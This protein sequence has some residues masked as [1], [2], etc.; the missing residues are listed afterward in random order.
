MYKRQEYVIGLQEGIKNDIEKLMPKETL[1]M[2][3]KKDT[4]VPNPLVAMRAVEIMDL[5]VKI[6]DKAEVNSEATGN[7]IFLTP[8]TLSTG[9]IN[10]CYEKFRSSN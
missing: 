4:H 9:F 6:T 10:N 2:M 5:S 8:L 7:N 1:V 3:Q